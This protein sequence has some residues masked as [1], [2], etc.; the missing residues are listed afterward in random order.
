MTS[1]AWDR[2]AGVLRF[3]TELLAGVIR[4]DGTHHGVA[5]LVYRPTGVRIDQGIA[6]ALYRLLCRDGWMGEAREMGHVAVPTEDGVEVRW[7]PCLAHQVRLQA[8]FVIREPGLIDCIID[9][10]G[11]SFYRDYELFLSSY[12]TSQFRPGVYL[13]PVHGE[14]LSGPT[15]VLPEANPIFR[16]MYLAFPR[17]ERAAHLITDGRWQRGRHWTRFL[18]ARYYGLPL[19]FYT[20]REGVVDVLLMGRPSDTFAVN[21]AYA[22]LDPID[23]VGQHNSLYLSLFGRDLH[24]G[25]RWQTAVRLVVGTFGRDS[26]THRAQYEHFLAY[27]GDGPRTYEVTWNSD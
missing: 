10:T 26:A 20:Q 4:A 14:D 23:R 12:F 19:G 5:D 17:D 6:L 24:P 8:R 13:Q 25:E 7:E 9:V 15:Q 2:Q 16:E 11:K 1:L 21:M 27:Y 3:E 18:P 22:T